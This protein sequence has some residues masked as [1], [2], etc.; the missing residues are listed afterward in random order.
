MIR[1]P[2]TASAWPV[3]YDAA[4]ESRKR[5]DLGHL[6]RLAPALLQ[7]DALQARLVQRL[8]R[9]VAQ[10][11]DLASTLSCIGVSV[12]PGRIA[13]TR[14]PAGPNQ[15]ARLRVIASTAAFDVPYDER[16]G[17]GVVLGRDGREVD[18]A[19]ARRHAHA[20]VAGEEEE[21]LHVDVED[22]VPVVLGDVGDGEEP[23]DARGVDEPV[24]LAGDVQ[25][26]RTILAGS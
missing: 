21:R 10:H 2:S 14:T 25:Q 23:D 16:L 17:R 5:I 8:R 9:R 11:R 15:F 18:D 3:M 12:M 24:D 13:L 26:P 20:E 22:R 7:R 6:A 1:P 19:G 4:L